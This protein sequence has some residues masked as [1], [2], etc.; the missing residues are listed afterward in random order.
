[1]LDCR[2]IT[3][4]AAIGGGDFAL[5]A[6]V[7]LQVALSAAG[8]A[9]DGLT[10]LAL[11]LAGRRLDLTSMVGAV[12]DDGE[13][14]ALVEASGGARPVLGG[15]L[16]ASRGRSRTASWVAS[17]PL[18]LVA[19]LAA[20]VAGALAASWRSLGTGQ[21]AW[22]SVALELALG[23][24]AAAAIVLS[25]ALAARRRW[26][27][28]A[29]PV[30]VALAIPA[31]AL[32]LVAVLGWP[33][34]VVGALAGFLPGLLL[35]APGWSLR[36]PVEQL[37]DIAGNATN[38]WTVRGPLPGRPRPIRPA[39]VSAL[40]EAALTRMRAAVTAVSLAAVVLTPAMLSQADQSSLTRWTGL[41]A[42]IL[43]ALGLV[44]APRGA[45]DRH[46]RLAPR[47][48]AGVVALELGFWWMRAGGEAW[49]P[50]AVVVGVGLVAV[51]ASVVAAR[52]YRSI[53]LSRLGDAAQF[54]AVVFGPPAALVAVNLLELARR[55]AS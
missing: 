19:F 4:N 28:L 44:L 18:A 49:L 47:L 27:D 30:A 23:A 10:V 2:R 7:P 51:F 39:A 21:G 37:V 3:V 48:A 20:A 36:V 29:W 8:F 9:V 41:A 12:L 54:L 15:A 35:A 25:V 32:V 16:A 50:V 5:P 33:V 1:M 6:D 55:A 52:G 31:V 40:M 38:R 34:G 45:A 43:V 26:R 11:D 42:A 14:I 46:T 17:R 13:V 22:S 24:M 53:G